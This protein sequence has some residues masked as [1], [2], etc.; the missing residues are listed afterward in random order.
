[1]RF[2]WCTIVLCGPNIEMDPTEN[3][4]DK[5]YFE[6]YRLQPSGHSKVRWAAWAARLPTTDTCIIHSAECRICPENTI[7]NEK[8]CISKDQY[9]YCCRASYACSM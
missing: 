2:G 5:N 8:Q 7:T 3:T 9:I 6:L 1:M 4:Y